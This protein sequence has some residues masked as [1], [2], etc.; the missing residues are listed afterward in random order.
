MKLKNIKLHFLIL[1]QILITT[2]ILSACTKKEEEIKSS[3]E[4][5]FQ[6]GMVGD[7]PDLDPA[8]ATDLNSL[9]VINDIFEGLVSL[10]PK[11]LDPKPAIAEH[12]E[13]S[14]DKRVYTFH[15]R[16]NARFSDGKYITA[17]DFKDS[18]LR[19]LD[20]KTASPYAYF[21]FCIKNAKEYYNN[22]IA[23]VKLL[24]IDVKDT[25]TLVISLTK[26][27]PYFLQ[28][29]SFP[30]F[31]PVPIEVINR[32]RDRWTNKENIVT[33]GPFVIT[34]RVLN[35]YIFTKTNNFYW[36]KENI[37]IKGV[38]YHTIEDL[39]TAYKMFLTGKLHK[40][41]MIPQMHVAEA[42][43][44]AE[45]RSAPVFSTT[46]FRF[47]TNKKPL[48]NE[49]VRRAL[50]LSIDREKLVKYV[51]RSAQ[52]PAKAVVPPV[53]R[54]YKSQSKSLF[55]PKE[56]KV[57]LE[58]AGY[59]NGLNFPK[60]TI[61]YASQEDKKKIL[62]AIREMWKNNLNI[63]VDILNIERKT[64]FQNER[65]LNYD[66]SFNNWYGDYFDPLSF[67]EVWKSDSG[68]SRTGWKDKRY[69][70]FLLSASEQFNFE[71]RNHMLMEAENYLLRSAPIVPLYH[72]TKD[73]LLATNIKGIYDNPLYYQP[74]KYIEIQ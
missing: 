15:L 16:K 72:D 10:D 32:H 69:D 23:N 66:I 29:L 48:N 70:E 18:L 38:K 61:S 46:F 65:S 34:D 56:A 20:S 41:T 36:D 21:L 63:E 68:N 30:V 55:R 27:I 31:F 51:L 40:C 8:L 22:L 7:V 57:L 9:Y 47:N 2:L 73:Y 35:S 17:Q 60:I 62:L 4:N 13:V 3:S 53:F 58:K 33:S 42:G 52:V 45:F 49:K 12:W 19:V 25:N 71:V 24:G 43:K 54:S 26:P 37:K 50:L 74:V 64:F 6:Y 44:L 67:L 5:I 11:T 1:I 59:K 28:L 14:K 39:N